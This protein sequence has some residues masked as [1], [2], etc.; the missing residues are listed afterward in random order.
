[1][2]N[3]SE[4]AIKCEKKENTDGSEFTEDGIDDWKYDH[5]ED[6]NRNVID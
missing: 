1:M 3:Y 4:V 5:T 2:S 6:E